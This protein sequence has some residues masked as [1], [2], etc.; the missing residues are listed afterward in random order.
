MPTAAPPN[1]N[2]CPAPQPDSLLRHAVFFAYTPETTPADI[3]RIEAAFAA[4]PDQIDGILAFERGVN[5]SPENLAKG[6]THAYLL[7]FAS[8]AARDAYLP[9][10]AHAAFGELLTPH[11]A[12]VLVID[13]W[14]T[15]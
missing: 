14:A 8:A 2:R 7:T 3:D 11:L 9:H 12:D 5:V 10:P 15:E 6:L 13:Y 4:L 1:P